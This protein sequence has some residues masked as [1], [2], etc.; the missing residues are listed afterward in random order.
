MRARP[1]T[2]R[3]RSST[4]GDAESADEVEAER[5]A[6]RGLFR[7]E[8]SAAGGPVAASAT[9]DHDEHDLDGCKTKTHEL[10]CGERRGLKRIFHRKQT[11]LETG[12]LGKERGD[13]IEV[14]VQQESSIDKGPL[15]GVQRQ[16]T[17][18]G[19]SNRTV[20]D[21]NPDN[22]VAAASEVS[23]PSR[24]IAVFRESG[25]GRQ[26]A[27]GREFERVGTHTR[28]SGIQTSGGSEDAGRSSR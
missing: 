8:S 5:T 18:V 17:Q 26:P 22:F 13:D 4:R 11:S 2:G 9:S 27:K 7:Q 25:G 21:S 28:S 10:H 24:P 3:R 23:P 1:V 14:I 15:A 20:L 16:R 6:D 19:G 12:G